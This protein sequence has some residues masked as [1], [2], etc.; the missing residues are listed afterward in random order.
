M[1]ATAIRYQI[2]AYADTYN[3]ITG[4]ELRHGVFD[5]RETA[6]LAFIRT[7]FTVEDLAFVLRWLQTK[8]QAGTRNPGC[9]KFS[10]LIMRPDAFEEELALAK[11]EK[12]NMRPP[13]TPKQKALEQLRPTVSDPPTQVTARPVNELIAEL[14]RSA[15]MTKP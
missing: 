1:T 10:N 12:R 8:I 7:G 2:Q 4:F 11:A 14:R 5:H 3:Q 15:G 6:W 9:L 13:Q